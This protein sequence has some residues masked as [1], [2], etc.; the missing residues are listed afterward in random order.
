MYFGQN[1]RSRGLCL[2][3]ILI[4]LSVFLLIF[5]SLVS[6][7]LSATDRMTSYL[8]R[9]HVE[10]RLRFI[11]TFLGSRLFYCGFGMPLKSDSYREA[12]GDLGYAPYNWDGPIS[13]GRPPSS[14]SN[15]GADNSALFIA[16]GYP[17]S[18]LISYD[19]LSAGGN[20][21]IIV[22]E[23]F[24]NDEVVPYGGGFCDTRSWLLF[25]NV[26]SCGTPLKVLYS[27]GRRIGV[28]S[29]YGREFR[30]NRNDAAH[31]FRALVVFCRDDVM[32]TYDFKTSG[33][34][35]RMSGI[36]DLRFEVDL[37]DR[38]VTVYALVRGNKKYAEP[39]RITNGAVWPQEF[40]CGRNT[41]ENYCLRA[42]K[43]VWGLPNCT[44]DGPLFGQNVAEL[45]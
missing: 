42:A 10:N 24:E 11:E 7:S 25:G 19:S 9:R 35:P 27:N 14:L 20:K 13:T 44:G 38:K 30:L 41:D 32:Y 39:Q 4:A 21:E 5:P 36:R 2:T 37:A 31:L 45:F 18:N 23:P 28:T 6:V 29:P 40:G 12:F 8:D 22:G 43:F 33:R 17:S 34:Q 15:D 3:E 16:F 26:S 1:N